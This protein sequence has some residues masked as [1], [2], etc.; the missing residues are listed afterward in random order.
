MFSIICDLWFREFLMLTNVKLR[1]PFNSWF[2][3]DYIASNHY[4][5]KITK[6]SDQFCWLGKWQQIWQKPFIIPRKFFA[7]GG[8]WRLQHVD[9][10]PNH[11]KLFNSIP[12]YMHF[13]LYL[14][15][16]KES[17]IQKYHGL[18]QF[19]RSS[20]MNWASTT[21]HHGSKFFFTFD[22][23]LQVYFEKVYKAPK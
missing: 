21:R 17:E 16:V 4:I 10:P 11:L 23:H 8:F 15:R 5:L 7:C 13:P 22:W 12:E 9:F 18:P 3:I 1:L 19:T 14:N 2:H 20:E 6:L